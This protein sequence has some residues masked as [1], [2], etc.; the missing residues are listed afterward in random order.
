MFFFVSPRKR[1]RLRSR[2][3]RERS[4]WYQALRAT[5]ECREGAKAHTGDL[6]EA[7]A[8]LMG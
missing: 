1:K 4:S 6:K 7:E 2:K 8:H 3:V 5:K